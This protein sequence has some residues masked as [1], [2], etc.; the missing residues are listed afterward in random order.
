M[1]NTI[2]VSPFELESAMKEIFN[3][4]VDDVIEDTTEALQTVGKATQQ[5]VRQ[6]INEAGIGGTRYK[7]SIRL[8]KNLVTRL[9]ASVT[10]HSPKLYMMTHLLENGHHL[11]YFGRDTNTETKAR[12]HWSAAEAYAE[13]ELMKAVRKAIEQ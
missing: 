12:P 6:K 4:Y 3:Q 1:S 9:S 8:K 7:N 11:V 5:M 13:K 10:I 2:H